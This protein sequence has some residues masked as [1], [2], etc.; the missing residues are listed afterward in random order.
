[1]ARFCIVLLLLASSGISI[2]AQAPARSPRCPVLARLPADL[3]DS[4]S[5]EE[6]LWF[7]LRQCNGETVTV[8]AY[9]RNRTTPSLKVETGYAY[10]G[11]LFHAFNILVLESIGGSANHVTVIIFHDG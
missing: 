3:K 4:T 11:L 7:E 6:R 5:E 10:P 8:Y 1:M 2:P 9:E